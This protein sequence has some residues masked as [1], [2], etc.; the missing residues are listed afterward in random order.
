M[1]E[2]LVLLFSIASPVIAFL[3]ARRAKGQARAIPPL[4][5]FIVASI[6]FVN[7]GFIAYYLEHAPEVWAQTA[8]LSVSWGILL[9]GLGGFVAAVVLRAPP[10]WLRFSRR[11]EEHD[12]S[13]GVAMTAAAMIFGIVLLYFYFLGYVPLF[14]ALSIML[15]EGLRKGLLNTLRVAR[16]VYV[17]PEARYIPLQGLMESFRY[18]GL[19]IVAIWSIHFYRRRVHPRA[20]LFLLA[21]AVLLILS[22]GQRW[23]LMYMLAAL[24][25]YFTWV[26]RGYKRAIRRVVLIGIIFGLGTTILL[27]RFEVS[28][29]TFGQLILRGASDLF[30]RILFGNVK[31]PFLSYQIFPAEKGWLYGQSWWQDL[32][33]HLPG[34]QP[35]FP[36]AFYQLVTGDPRGFTA[37]PDFYTEAYINFGWLGVTV[38]SLCWGVM[39]SMFQIL[40]GSGRQTLLRISL[41]AVLTMAVGFSVISG[42]AFLLSL[43]YV[44]ICVILLLCALEAISAGLTP[45]AREASGAGAY[46]WL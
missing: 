6:L 22:S 33:A 19:P 43:F 11:P 18:W 35:S 2:A 14:R 31:I 23:P 1:D 39:L 7:I 30:Q 27:A 38:F 36:V 45:K 9:V 24:A 4:L 21:M 16:D 15:T 26:F 32:R 41:C 3:L 28:G 44:G 46:P 20:S 12:I 25:V 13:Y 29:L 10:L 8:V 42:V 5:A 34:P 40:I 17:N 37:P